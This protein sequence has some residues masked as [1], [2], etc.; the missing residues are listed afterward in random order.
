[1]FLDKIKA[2]NIS[3]PM[4]KLIEILRKQVNSNFQASLLEILF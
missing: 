4:Q 1:M 2:E 3:Q